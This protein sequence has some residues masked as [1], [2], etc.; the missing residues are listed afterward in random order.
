MER[1]RFIKNVG[2]NWINYCVKTLDFIVDDAIIVL[3]NKLI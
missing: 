3:Y 1:M 2:K